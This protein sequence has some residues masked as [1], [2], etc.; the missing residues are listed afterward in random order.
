[1]AARTRRIR[2]TPYRARS[3]RS[4]RLTSTLKR[5][6]PYSKRSKSSRSVAW[7][8]QSRSG[9]RN[10]P[11]R[12]NSDSGSSGFSKR[13]RKSAIPRGFKKILA[14]QIIN[15][16]V[17]GVIGCSI[18]EQQPAMLV[19]Y[20][21]EQN[22]RWNYLLS[23]ADTFDMQLVLQAIEPTTA[24]V[25]AN[26]NS[27]MTRRF[28]VKHVRAKYTLKN[29]TNIPIEV[30]L[31]DI[32]PKR[33]IQT[34]SGQ[35]PISM[36][37]SGISNQSVNIT[38]GAVDANAMVSRFPG[39]TPFQSQMFCQYWT[40]KK[41]T[42]FILHAGSEHCHYVNLRPKYPF[43]YELTRQTG[44]IRNLTTGVLAVIQGGVAQDATNTNLAG[45]SIAEL[46]YTCEVQYSFT[47]MERSRTLYT[48][49]NGLAGTA[50]RVV[51]EDTDVVTTTAVV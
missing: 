30:V 49:Y 45:T 41:K 18:N 13:S 35:D 32:Q 31:Y 42:S 11:G 39:S 47:A 14:P 43:N 29:A 8:S 38:G 15:S 25:I 40:V 16:A 5:K 48:Q 27:Y 7:S 37:N 2:S 21:G 23:Q 6:A 3:T 1:M 10:L 46:A 12:M 4:K 34:V 33:D 20:T 24:T 22:T 17:S 19:S 51:L 9:R 36:W 44:F 26:T 50:S 28:M